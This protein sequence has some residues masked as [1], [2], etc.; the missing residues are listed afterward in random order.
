MVDEGTETFTILSGTTPIGTPVTVNV[1][2]GAAGRDLRP[3]GGHA[4]RHLHHPGRLQRHPELR[5]IV[6]HMPY[7]D[8]RRRGHGHRRRQRF[9]SVSAAARRMSALSATIT[10][11]AGVVNEGTETFTIL[12]GT[13]PIG[14]PVTV[15]VAAGAAVR[16]LR[17]AGGHAGRHLHHPGRLQ[18][19]DRTSPGPPTAATT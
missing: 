7:P 11:P 5:R 4:S 17:P 3:A 8:R 18:R 12:S 10:S 15:N 1:A 6:R 9:G 19:H 13:T 16:D 14:T 2:A